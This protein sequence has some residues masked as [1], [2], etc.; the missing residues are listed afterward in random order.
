MTYTMLS[1]IYV[2]AFKI[3]LHYHKFEIKRKRSIDKIRGKAMT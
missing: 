3:I 2:I 1:N